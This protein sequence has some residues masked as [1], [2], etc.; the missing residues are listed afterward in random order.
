MNIPFHT[1]AQR[2]LVF[3][4]IVVWVLQFGYGVRLF[5]QW[6]KSKR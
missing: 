6:R 3:V 2:N 4:Y 5:V 1:L